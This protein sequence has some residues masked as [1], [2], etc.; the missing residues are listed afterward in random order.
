MLGVRILFVCT[1]NICRS[2]MGERLTRAF[3]DDAVGASAAAVD[4]MSAG[5]HAVVGSEMEPSS[6]LALTGLGGMPEGFCAQQLNAGMI[7]SA[8]LT[9][10]MTRQHRRSV[11]KLAPRAMFR[12]FTLR[13]AADL[14]EGVDQSA[15]PP[16]SRFEERGRAL[17]HA[18]G[19]QR[20]TRR[21]ADRVD[22]VLDPIGH[23]ASVHQD[24]GQQILDALVPL[25][26]ALCEEDGAS[27]SG[28][29]LQRALQARLSGG[30]PSGE[31]TLVV[32]TRRR[33]PVRAAITRR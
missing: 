21:H 16:A 7:D 25:L 2:P 24:V 1:G 18:L 8:E 9:L 3:L 23:C 22:D 10:T 13:E 6:A 32:P 4:T 14:L 29:V 20:A 27:R 26:R 28:G 15:L 30:A 17:V 31:D 33:I 19:R 12:T 11:L 5:T